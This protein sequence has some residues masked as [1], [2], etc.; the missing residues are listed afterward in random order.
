MYSNELGRLPIYGQ[1]NF[2]DVVDPHARMIPSN[3]SF[4]LPNVMYGLPSLSMA[5]S[6]NI[7]HNGI[8]FGGM[9]VP[10][11]GAPVNP[12]TLYPA[13]MQSAYFLDPALSSLGT[14]VDF[15]AGGL[16]AHTPGFQSQG[17][18]GQGQGQGQGGGVTT[19][20]GSGGGGVDFDAM[21]GTMPAMD[22]DMMTMWTTA[23]TS[24]E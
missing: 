10:G 15:G 24:L 14:G 22:N 12:Q 11:V 21:F 13:N 20:F 5:Q 1:F 17:L 7:S 23:P 19:M 9:S 18:G 2:S 6:Q 4:N 3:P 8:S 16:N